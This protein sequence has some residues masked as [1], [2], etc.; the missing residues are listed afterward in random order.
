MTVSKPDISIAWGSTGGVVEPTDTKKGDGF[1][2]EKVTY[3]MLNW[4]SNREDRYLQHV[5]AEGIPVWDANTEYYIGCLAKDPTNKKI[6]RSKVDS[7][8]GNQPSTASTEWEPETDGKYLPLIG[9]VVAG[10]VELN[11]PDVEFRLTGGFNGDGKSF[12]WRNDNAGYMTLY[13]VKSDD[14]IAGVLNFS[15][16]GVPTFYSGSLPKVNEDPTVDNHLVRKAYADTMLPLAGG[17]MSGQLKSVNS[18]PLSFKTASGANLIRWNRADDTIKFDFG[19]YNT[20]DNM[21]LYGYDASSAV[22]FYTQ[23]K[24]DGNIELYTGVVP[25]SAQ[26]LV[27]KAYADTFLPLTSGTITGT[28]TFTG[29]S[30]VKFKNSGEV[31]QLVWYKANGDY[32]AH[33]GS[34]GTTDNLSIRVAASGVS[35][36]FVFKGATGNIEVSPGVVPNS[37]QDL[38]TKDYVDNSASFSTGTKLAFFQSSAPTGWTQDTSNNDAMLRVVSGSGGGTGGSNSP[39]LY[40]HAHNLTQHTHD[41]TVPNAGW[42]NKNN[43]VSGHLATTVAGTYADEPSPG[44]RVLTSAQQASGNTGSATFAPKYV[45]MIICTRD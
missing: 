19:T 38:A 44:D 15:G 28:V 23:F 20:S 16:A 7:N 36:D 11:Y 2:V 8:S 9:G 17:T 26:D 30:P 32:K 25:S 42:S 35:K 29:T 3:Q 12:F 22:N 33:I 40:T 27:T 31:A 24:G 1:I 6:Y 41:V 21:R 18:V 34:T 45:D 5:N 39:I 43:N 37:S 14:S 10:S 4:I 13:R